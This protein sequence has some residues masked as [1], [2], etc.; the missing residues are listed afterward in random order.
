MSEQ[1]SLELSWPLN[2]GCTI[3]AAAP[4]ITSTF[5]K[6]KEEAENVASVAGK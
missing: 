1:G 3:I 2:H 4:A 6:N 5:I